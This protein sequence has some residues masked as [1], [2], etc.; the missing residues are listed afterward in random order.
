MDYKHLDVTTLEVARQLQYGWGTIVQEFR[1]YREGRCVAAVMT[2]DGWREYQCSRSNG[3]GPEQLFCFQH[4]QIAE[5]R[6]K[7]KEG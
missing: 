7:R 4:A 3:Y 5:R 1:R 2:K 6:R